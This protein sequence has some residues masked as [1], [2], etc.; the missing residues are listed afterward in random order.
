MGVYLGSPDGAEWRNNAAADPHSLPARVEAALVE[1]GHPLA[2]F[3][4]EP[5][6]FEE[7]F[8]RVGPGDFD[9]LAQSALNGV[10]FIGDCAEVFVPLPIAATILAKG[11][12]ILPG[13]SQHRVE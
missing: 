11:P 12:G 6:S 10:S 4:D 5:F 1:A 3:G 2:P 9:K 7:K 13:P 8:Y